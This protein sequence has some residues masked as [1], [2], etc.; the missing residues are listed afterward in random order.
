MAGSIEIL[1][2]ICSYSYS[3]LAVPLLRP[4]V[5]G[6]QPKKLNFDIQ[7]WV[8]TRWNNRWSQDPFER[9]EEEHRKSQL[10]SILATTLWRNTMEA[11]QDASPS[12]AESGVIA[13]WKKYIGSSRPLNLKRIGADC[14][15]Q[16][17]TTAHFDSHVLGGGFYFFNVHPYLGKWS[18][19]TM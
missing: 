18:N 5:K 11:T 15:S 14:P 19:L 10:M 1:N 4:N 16:K 9:L 8:R 13:A 2:M 6:K 17:K 12:P 7:T 3:S